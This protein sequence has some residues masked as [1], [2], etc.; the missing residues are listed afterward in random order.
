MIDMIETWVSEFPLVSVEDGLDEEDWDGW[1]LLTARLG[2]R[3]QLV[4]DDLFATNRHRVERGIRE[5]CR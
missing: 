4:G 2:D 1:A 3:L 5:Q